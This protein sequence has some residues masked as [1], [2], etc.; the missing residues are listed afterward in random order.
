M[1][2]G[3]CGICIAGAWLAACGST[4]ST[5]TA[6]PRVACNAA[7]RVGEWRYALVAPLYSDVENITRVELAAMWRGT[8]T[9]KLVVAADTRDALAPSLGTPRVELASDRVEVS[10]E[11]WAV[12]PADE[13]TPLWKVITVDGKHP[14]TEVNALV[15]PLCSPIAGRV[16]NI[17][18]DALTTVAM[19]GVTAMTRFTAKLMDVKGV[20]YPAQDVAPWFAH[21]DFVH[22]SNEVS[23][24]STCEPKGE[25]TEPF[26]SRDNYIELLDALHV[27]IVE[28]TGDHLADFGTRWFK[29]TIDMYEARG[30]KTFGGGR[31]QLAATKPL[32]VEHHGNKL[33][34]IGCNMPR[35]RKETIRSGPENAFCD[36]S[37]LDWQVR[38]LRSRGYLPIVSL[39][40]DEV[41]GHDPPHQLVRDFRRLA[42]AGAAA[43]FG[44]QAHVAHPFEVHAGAYLLYGA[45]N[46]IFDQPWESTR[47]GTA[48][49]YYIHHGRLLTVAQLFTH[50]EEQGRPRPMTD[51]ERKTFLHTLADSLATLPPAKPWLA[52][53]AAQ[54]DRQAPD[55][56]LVDKAPV[57]LRIAKPVVEAT[58]YPLVID[59]RAR[60]AAADDAFTVTLRKWPSLPR[61]QL[62]RAITEFM[63][64]KY[65]IDS[66]RVTIR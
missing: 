13:L 45:G 24:V 35:S 49:R 12:V 18:P 19:T 41:R 9:H 66:D 31:D 52:Q 1:A 23:F 20:T 8:G 37:R 17:D 63:T 55:S 39:Q 21:T 43:V 25:F 6:P 26:C 57:L 40:H 64:A 14:L 16:R 10:D 27:N 32:L 11:R 15:V 59:L 62:V 61:K 5:R 38:D 48:V 54:S 46:F 51:D 30:W 36:E 47:A 33:A 56:F 53:D 44:S 34:F 42:E 58:R 28:L 50:L 7:N 3:A 2:A 65:P 29:H 4:P 22:V 60:T